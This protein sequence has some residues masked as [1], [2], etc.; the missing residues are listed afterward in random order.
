MAQV[1]PSFTR[2]RL[3]YTVNIT[4]NFVAQS[5]MPWAWYRL[6]SE[7]HGDNGEL[8]DQTAFYD[9]VKKQARLAMVTGAPLFPSPRNS[10]PHHKLDFAPEQDE[11]LYIHYRVVCGGYCRTSSVT[12]KSLPRNN[13]STP[14]NLK[15]QQFVS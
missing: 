3:V 10:H 13:S 5:A 11:N 12:P 4:S 2:L 15:C 8:G 6:L 9:Q 7:C 14:T 1:R